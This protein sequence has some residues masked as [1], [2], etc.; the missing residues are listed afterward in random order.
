MHSK[1][2]VD[3]VRFRGDRYRRRYDPHT[4]RPIQYDP[5]T[6][7]LYN[8]CT[9][10]KALFNRFM[11]TCVANGMLTMLSGGLGMS[12]VRDA[13]TDE[14]DGY[15]DVG[16]AESSSSGTAGNGYSQGSGGGGGFAGGAGGGGGSAP[17]TAVAQASP[18]RAAAVAAA[19]APSAVPQSPP[20][21]AGMSTE[22]VVGD[23]YKHAYKQRI[24]LTHSDMPT[25]STRLE[26]ERKLV[27]P[28]VT[29]VTGSA[30]R[31]IGER[32]RGRGREGSSLASI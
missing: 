29:A 5:H 26:R 31:R 8:A 16:G 6:G 4:V 27:S 7:Q 22:T 20:P 14:D 28:A 9:L 1:G 12:P 21:S 32:E 25:L 18:Q 19:A 13:D 2:F 10:R 23:P 30:Q 11:L 24:S 17:L 15:I 3:G